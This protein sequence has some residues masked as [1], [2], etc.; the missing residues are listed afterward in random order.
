MLWRGSCHMAQRDGDA[1][2]CLFPF[3]SSLDQDTRIFGGSARGVGVDVCRSQQETLNL[4][5]RDPYQRGGTRRPPLITAYTVYLTNEPFHD[6][7]HRWQ[8]RLLISG[9]LSNQAKE[10]KRGQGKPCR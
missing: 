10:S 9:I 3:E 7:K 4:G 6:G 2:R 8:H 5:S 1:Q